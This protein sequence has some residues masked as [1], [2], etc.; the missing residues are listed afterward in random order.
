MINTQLSFKEQI[1][2][3]LPNELPPKRSYP[4]NANRAPKRKDSLTKAEKKLAVQNA[5]RYFPKK[6]HRIL[7][8]ELSLIHI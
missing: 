2:Q 8:K 4:E 5:L 7:A 6:W 1:L 3:G